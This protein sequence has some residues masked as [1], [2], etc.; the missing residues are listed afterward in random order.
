MRSPGRTR[1]HEPVHRLERRQ[2]QRHLPVRFQRCPVSGK[3]PSTLESL[4]SVFNQDLNGDGTVGATA[5]FIQTERFDR[6]ADR[7]RRIIPSSNNTSSGTGPALNQSWRSRFTAA[8]LGTGTPVRR[9]VA[10]GGYE[11]AWQIRRPPVS[12]PFGAPLAT[13]VT[14]L[15]SS[16]SP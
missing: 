14:V 3:Q 8:Q 16:R 10:G 4:E 1:H 2:W 11:V 9:C 7:G 6:R 12:T 15:I 13:A 5:I